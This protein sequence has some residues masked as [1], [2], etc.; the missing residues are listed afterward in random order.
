MI[1]HYSARRYLLPSVGIGS[2]THNR[3]FVVCGHWL[4]DHTKKQHQKRQTIFQL[5]TTQL[6][7]EENLNQT[8][9]EK[10]IVEPQILNKMVLLKLYIN[11]HLL[12][13]SQDCFISQRACNQLCKFGESVSPQT[14]HNRFPRYFV[15]LVCHKVFSNISS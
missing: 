14:D 3:L 9:D 8:M 10:E 11:I 13:Q 6:S 2:A 12:L 7:H 4:P 15:S 1:T 5:I